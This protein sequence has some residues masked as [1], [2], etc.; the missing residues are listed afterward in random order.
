MNKIYGDTEYSDIC[1]KLDDGTIFHAHKV[2]LAYSGSSYFRSVIY[3]KNF[4][5]STTNIVELEDCSNTVFEI[6]L[7]HAYGVL[8]FKDKYNDIEDVRNIF[9]A[10]SRF[11]CT[12]LV[13]VLSSKMIT[14]DEQL[15]FANVVLDYGEEFKHH[16]TSK[17]LSIIDMTIDHQ[18]LTQMIE[19][20][21]IHSFVIE[22]FLYDCCNQQNLQ[23]IDNDLIVACL[24]KVDYTKL[25]KMYDLLRCLAKHNYLPYQEVLKLLHFQDIHILEK[26]PLKVGIVKT[27]KE[28]LAKLEDGM[29]GWTLQFASRSQH[30]DGIYKIETYYPESL[31]GLPEENLETM[32]FVIYEDF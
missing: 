17:Y 26:Y 9:V 27:Y 10:A 29:M 18:K 11:D 1:F 24:K 32:T 31:K 30:I 19:L 12:E 8:T 15:I 20:M 5:E 23:T 13:I 4:K 7:K 22:G 2:I 28:Y 25:I 21:K 3:S 6:A 16:L 14:P